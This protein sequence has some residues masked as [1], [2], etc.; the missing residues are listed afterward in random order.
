MFSMKLLQNTKYLF[1][2]VD[3]D[4]HYIP[5]SAL[6]GD[7]VVNRSK[8]MDWYAGAPLTPHIRNNAHQQ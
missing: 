6:D 8:N 3:Q 1:K 5:I 7:N 2:N 4:V